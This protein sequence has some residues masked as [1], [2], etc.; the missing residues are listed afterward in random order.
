MTEQCRA[1]DSTT[2]KRC[3]KP[4]V[5]AV[6]YGY[7]TEP[8]CGLHMTGDEYKGYKIRWLERHTTLAWPHRRSELD[9]EKPPGELGG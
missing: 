2:H 9:T 1:Y 7:R 6:D 8:L 3:K 5:Q 4:A